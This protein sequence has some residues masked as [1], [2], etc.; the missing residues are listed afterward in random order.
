MWTIWLEHGDTPPE[1][2]GRFKN[3][4]D[5]WDEVGRIM[6]DSRW[7][8]STCIVREGDAVIWHQ[9]IPAKKGNI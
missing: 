6:T 5:M 9:R 4:D 7:R 8:G 3:E 2:M 1:P